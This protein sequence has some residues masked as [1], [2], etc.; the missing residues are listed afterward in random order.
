MRGAMLVCASSKEKRVWEH[1]DRSFEGIVIVENDYRSPP[2]ENG[3]SIAGNQ[4]VLPY[5]MSLDLL[6]D[7]KHLQVTRLL[8]VSRL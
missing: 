2:S 3:R 7:Q 4:S 8:S 5:H 6:S 1:S